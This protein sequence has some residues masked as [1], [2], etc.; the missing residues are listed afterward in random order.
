VSGLRF[1]KEWQL[2]AL[3]RLPAL[4][5]GGRGETAALPELKEPNNNA[6]DQYGLSVETFGTLPS[7]CRR[8]LSTAYDKYGLPKDVTPTQLGFG[9]IP[10]IVFM[11]GL[12]VR[13][14]RPNMAMGGGFVF[15]SELLGGRRLPG[16]TVADFTV[17]VGNRVIAV[18]VDSFFHS[19][20][21]PFGGAAK[22][23]QEVRLRLRLL[24]RAQVDAVIRVSRVEEG[25]P[26][27]KGP[28]FLVYR[29][30]E[31]VLTA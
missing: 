16:G 21:N 4:P 30:F 31:R 25:N 6:T 24:S 23:E 18:Y 22:I 27:E 19:P 11:G 15:Q 14:Y 1:P 7:I 20:Q 13:G 2:P 17:F 9:T 8:Y 5:S 3:P 29:D 28:A 12:L 26:L 10:E